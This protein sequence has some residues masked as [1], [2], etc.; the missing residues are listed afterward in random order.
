MNHDYSAGIRLFN[1][2][3]NN[4]KLK[5]LFIK[6]DLS[7]LHSAFEHQFELDRIQFDC[8]SL[9]LQIFSKKL[10]NLVIDNCK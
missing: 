2:F 9:L 8:E 4:E 1:R 10:L 7:L 6:E 5:K 3:R